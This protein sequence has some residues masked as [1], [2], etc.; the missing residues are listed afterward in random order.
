MFKNLKLG[1]KLILS[2]IIVTM[3][4]SASGIVAAVMLTNT[5]KEYSSALENEGFGLGY[6][7]IH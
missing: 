2:F 3:V 5:D 7:V 6:R 4:A 1:V